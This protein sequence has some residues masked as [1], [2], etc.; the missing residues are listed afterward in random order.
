MKHRKRL[1]EEPKKEKIQ[2]I[3]Q[4]SRNEFGLPNIVIP[5]EALFHPKL[6]STEKILFGIINNLSATK[7]GC[8][9]C[10]RYLANFLNLKIQ[11]ISNAISTL[12]NLNFLEVTITQ[13]SDGMQVRRIFIN[14]NYLKKYEEMLIEAYKKINRGVILKKSKIPIKKIKDPYKNSLNK[15]DKEIDKEIDNSL[16]NKT[17]VFSKHEDQILSII[18]F[19]NNL[20]NSVTHSNPDT[21]IYKTI[22]LQID[23]LLSAC[24]LIC[25]KDNQPTKPFLDFID[26]NHLSESLWRKTWTEEGINNIFQVINDDVPEGEKISLDQTLWNAFAKRRGG[27]FSLFLYTASQAT[28]PKEYFKLTKIL[29]D[30]VGIR[31]KKNQEIEWAQDF[32]Q[33]AKKEEMPFKQIVGLLSWYKINRDNKYIPI[34]DSPQ[35]LQEKY[36]KLLRAKKRQ[37]DDPPDQKPQV[38]SPA[39]F[40]IIT[41]SYDRKSKFRKTV[42]EW[43]TL[44]EANTN[45]L[46][47]ADIWATNHTPN[48]IT[49]FNNVVSMQVWLDNVDF[50]LYGGSNLQNRIKP[51]HKLI[52][53]YTLCINDWWGDWMHGVKDNVFDV[54]NVNNKIFKMF[55]REIETSFPVRIEIK[56]DGW[57][58]DSDWEPRD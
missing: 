10:N 44:L 29:A 13:R 53:Y 48:K 47:N 33:F 46:L 12:K 56:S 7:D 42:A 26:Q 36:I 37:S 27:G 15:I 35:E 28:I 30:I 45:K 22:S 23:N 52:Y 25:K 19:W 54:N 24:P 18:N 40:P 16:I 14:K 49:M 3:D 58:N 6:S 32:Q 5:A 51:L 39:G 17:Y 41:R 38:L 9:A 43:Q 55:I 21:K 11:T 50:S 1:I 34:I 4:T 8:W 31:L 57:I 2:T 20:P